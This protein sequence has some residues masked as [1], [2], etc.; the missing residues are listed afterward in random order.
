[1]LSSPAMLLSDRLLGTRRGRTATSLAGSLCSSAY[2]ETPRP[3]EAGSSLSK[4]ELVEV[5]PLV[6]T[7]SIEALMAPGVNALLVLAAGEPH[8]AA[9]IA[10]VM[11]QGS[12][13]K[14]LEVGS[15]RYSIPV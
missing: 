13:D 11:L 8:Q 12:V 9:V 7:V 15:L 1:M 4:D 5:R 6:G 3:S 10:Q 14:L 2:A